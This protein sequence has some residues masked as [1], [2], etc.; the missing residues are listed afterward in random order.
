MMPKALGV[1]ST[2][3]QING[4][5]MAIL[6][7]W[8]PMPM[9]LVAMEAMLIWLQNTASSVLPVMQAIF[10]MPAPSRNPTK[11]LPIPAI[12]LP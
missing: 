12:C 9:I 2:S 6:V 10:I 5:T 4:P 7:Q 3:S 11:L 1:S 8:E